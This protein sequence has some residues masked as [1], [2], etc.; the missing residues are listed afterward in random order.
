MKS[1]IS[2]AILGAIAS[3]YDTG[4]DIKFMEHITKYG[5]SYFTMGEFTARKELF[6][7]TDAK[8]EEHNATDSLYRMGH[9]K[10]SDQTEYE[11][12]KRRGFKQNPNRSSEVEEV[13][14]DAVDLP[15]SWDWREKNAVTPVKDQGNCGACWTFSATGALE[16][17]HA[18]RSGDLVVFSEQEIIDCDVNDFDAGCDGGDE[19]DAMK[20][21]KKHFIMTENAY[22]YKA[23]NKKC[24][25]DKDEATNI[26]TESIH[27]VKAKSD[28]DSMKA[29][30]TKHGPLSV[31]IQADIDNYESGIF[32]NKKCGCDLDHSVLAVGY[33]VEN[34]TE[35]W[36]V[37]NSWASDW[38]EDG[39]I[40]FAI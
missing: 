5:K 21:L 18:I 19:I 1:Y 26:K 30:L 3:A 13:S 20:Y 28:P 22:P 14:F 8:I 24:K 23:K 38:G 36:I 10:F 32:D 4:L 29:A 15:E 9:N 2:A 16:G 40:R 12:K 11:R 35:Y 27:K 6:A 37:K 33:G 39:Y 7:A 17:A 25:Y 34:G 31:A